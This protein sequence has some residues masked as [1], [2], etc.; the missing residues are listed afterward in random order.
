MGVGLGGGQ[1]GT[2]RPAWRCRRA[3]RWREITPAQ[4]CEPSVNMDSRPGRRGRPETAPALTA[5]P[6]GKR[7]TSRGGSRS[8]SRSKSRQVREV[9]PRRGFAALVCRVS[10][11]SR[12]EKANA[13][14][15]PRV[16]LPRPSLRRGC[17]SVH[18]NG[19]VP[20]LTARLSTMTHP[21]TE[22][23]AQRVQKRSITGSNDDRMGGASG[24]SSIQRRARA[25]R[26]GG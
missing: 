1:T 23:Y 3:L 13:G 17:H 20:F 26:G 18:V 25:S 24:S 19:R 5:K 15:L 6:A 16:D 22:R 8:R 9:P 4:A 21:T 12:V 7:G 2:Y 10:K 11:C 14:I